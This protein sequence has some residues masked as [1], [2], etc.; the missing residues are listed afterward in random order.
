[1]NPSHSNI[2]SGDSQ[3]GVRHSLHGIATP[4]IDDASHQAELFRTWIQ[5]KLEQDKMIMAVASGGIGVLVTLISTN[6]I[7]GTYALVLS[8][9]AITAFVVATIGVIFIFRSNAKY[10]Y[11]KMQ[12]KEASQRSLMFLD[13]FVTIFFCLGIIGTIIVSIMMSMRN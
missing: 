3:P 12:N 8:G 5:L 4:A 10:I 11:A 7:F 6:M 13:T 2:E 9:V 1:M